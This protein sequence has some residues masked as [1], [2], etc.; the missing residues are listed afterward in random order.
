MDI[1]Q[2]LAINMMAV[3]ALAIAGCLARVSQASLKDA[4]S[5]LAANGAVLAAGAVALQWQ[6][7]WAGLIVAGLFVPFVVA[8]IVL[9]SL[10]QRCMLRNDMKAAARYGQIA[11][12]LLPGSGPRFTA[13]LAKALALET[14]SQKLAALRH[15]AAKSTAAEQGIVQAHAYRIADDWQGLLDHARHQPAAV[16]SPAMELRALGETKRI[17][18]MV[19]RYDVSKSRL[20]GL[21][22]VVAQLF[23]LAFSGRHEA[24]TALLTGQLVHL[25]GEAK[26][27]W[28][29]IAA[30]AAGK[31]AD[32]TVQ[33]LRKLAESSANDTIRTSAMRHLAIA[34]ALASGELS[35]QSV[36]IVDALDASV[37]Q[38]AAHKSA[39]LASTPL[40]LLLLALILATYAAEEIHGSGENMKTLVALG[41]MWPPYVL[42]RGEWWRLGS[43]LFLHFGWLHL[44]ANSLML[45]VLGR[46]CELAFG[47][48]RMA[49][50]YALGGLASSAF[51]LWLMASGFSDFAVLVGAS[52]AIMA[53]FGSLAGHRIVTWLRSRDPL[54]AR[55]LFMLAAIVA[56]QI[57]ADLSI[58][59][60]SL[61]AHASGMASGLVL[62]LLLAVRQHKPTLQSA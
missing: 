58:P 13:H 59:Q 35:A 1:Q 15:L 36:A 16:I 7:P 55:E 53:L 61:A 2:F 33:S 24:V 21:D 50:I 57:A 31:D 5:W 42:D 41:A 56:V 46:S 51:V 52:G 9:G 40:T 43:A 11:T 32:H 28:T 10:M 60:V 12:V 8:P 6:A 48:A 27:Y 25:D 22:L 49:L 17:D 47:S 4:W 29:A 38:A 20:H 26:S 37:Q 30:R 34:P 3:S 45:F 39:G 19:E 44:L 23:I 18:T 54:D 62:G 14:S